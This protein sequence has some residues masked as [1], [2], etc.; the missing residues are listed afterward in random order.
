MTWFYPK[1]GPVD[2]GGGG[3]AV[4]NWTALPSV[5]PGGM[6][7]IQELLGLLLYQLSQRLAPTIEDS[8]NFSLRAERQSSPQSRSHEGSAGLQAC[9]LLKG[10]LALRRMG[11]I[12]EPQAMARFE[13]CFESNVRRAGFDLGSDIG[14]TCRHAHLQESEPGL[15]GICNEPLRL[16]DLGGA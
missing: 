16:L 10:L 4:T 5:F 14:I 12:E 3:G 8:H 7:K 6:T 13:S 2:H 9:H 15:Y 1:D 11:A